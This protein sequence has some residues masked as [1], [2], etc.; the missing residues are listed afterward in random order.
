MVHFHDLGAK[1]VRSGETYVTVGALHELRGHA[2]PER[3]L[4]RTGQGA[5]P[6]GC[7][8]DEQEKKRRRDEQRLQPTLDAAEQCVERKSERGRRDGTGKDHGRVGERDPPEDVDAEPSGADEGRQSRHA[9]GHDGR[10]PDTSKDD[11]RRERQLDLPEHLKVRHSHPDRSFANGGR[12]AFDADDRVSDDGQERIQEQRHD[13]GRRADAD[14]RN[15]KSEKRET[16]Y[17]LQNAGDPENDR[18]RDAC[19]ATARSR[20]ADPR[21]PR[22]RGP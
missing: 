7:R 1:A 19:C 6:D 12:R 22:D 11:R 4:G 15:Q 5:M 9:Y 2:D 17:R 8:E 14:E 16:R 3:R 13:R 21:R 18:R 20:S 10:G